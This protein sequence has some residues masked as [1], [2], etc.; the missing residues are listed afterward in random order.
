MSKVATPRFDKLKMRHYL[1]AASIS[2]GCPFQC[3]FCDIIVTFNRRLNQDI[4]ADHRRARGDPRR[5][6]IVFVV[7][8]N[9][10]GNKKAIKKSC[11]T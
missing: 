8:D 2:R 6:A 5:N 4:A 1:L 9:L 3:E 10:I 11:A 7:D